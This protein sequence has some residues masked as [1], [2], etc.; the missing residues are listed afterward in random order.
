MSGW[1]ILLA[2]LYLILSIS[3]VIPIGVALACIFLA[4]RATT[5]VSRVL[6]AAL[7]V[8]PFL[9]YIVNVAI[10]DAGLARRRT[11]LAALPRVTAGPPPL[12]TLIVVGY[13]T[14]VEQA[15]LLSAYGFERVYMIQQHFDPF[16]AARMDTPLYASVT[17]RKD[18]CDGLTLAAWKD[19]GRQDLDRRASACIQTSHLN[20]TPA[21]LGRAAIV[22]SMDHATTLHQR[23]AAGAATLWAGGA[24]EV[25]RR[26]NGRDELVDYWENPHV[27]RQSSPLCFPIFDMCTTTTHNKDIDRLQFL[28]DALTRA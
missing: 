20:A 1:W 12:R 16:D 17:T 19:G 15:I 13:I 14:D 18:I 21:E 9:F 22:F 11:Q 28:T 8:S 6:Y 7:A 5:L 26:A 3:Y 10:T 25:R 27:E 23:N 4:L 24:Y 2:P